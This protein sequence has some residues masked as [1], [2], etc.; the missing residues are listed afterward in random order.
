MKNKTVLLFSGGVDSTA[1]LYRQ[2]RD[3][4]D[5]IY[6]HHI[7]FLN[8]EDR[9]YCEKIA[10]VSI[11]NYLRENIRPF[12]YSE[13]TFNWPGRDFI[14]WDIVTA[15]YIGALATRDVM[16]GDVKK[17]EYDEYSYRVA[18]GDNAD[19][20]N[21]YQWKTPVAQGIF[22]LASLSVPWKNQVIPQIIQPIAHLKKKDLID[23]MPRELFDLTWTCRHPVLSRQEKAFKEC[24]TC[25]SCKALKEL[26]Y[27]RDTQLCINPGGNKNGKIPKE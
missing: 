7:N 8:I 13:S 24:G 27:F 6:V 20:F 21:S 25:I 14:G 12:L 3:T 15:M 1:L 19:D 22:A 26:G 23:D 17:K 4:S 2:L 18:I 9:A 5:I 11:V 16:I 10:C